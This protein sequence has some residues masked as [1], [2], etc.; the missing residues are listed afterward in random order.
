LTC[1]QGKA[2]AAEIGATLYTEIS[3]KTRFGLNELFQSAI[4]IVLGKGA[5]GGKAGKKAASSGGKKS[6]LLL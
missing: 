1:P 3:S 5:A 2:L 4:D 6:C